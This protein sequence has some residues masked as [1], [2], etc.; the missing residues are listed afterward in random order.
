MEKMVPVWMQV[1]GWLGG[2]DLRVLPPD[3]LCFVLKCGS[4]L[5]TGRGKK[6]YY[7]RHRGKQVSCGFKKWGVNSGLKPSV[8]VWTWAQGS[9]GVEIVGAEECI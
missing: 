3:S 4:D 9:E 1:R 2:S 5:D 7:Q 6:E 8:C